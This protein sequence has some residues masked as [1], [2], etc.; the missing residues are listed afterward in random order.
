MQENKIKVFL[1]QFKSAV[2]ST[3]D[4]DNNPFSSYAPIL[5]LDNIFYVHISDIARHSQNI[6]SNKKAS[7]FFIEDESKTQNIFARKRIVFQCNAQMIEKD[8]LKYNNILDTFEETIEEDTIKHLRT[9]KDFNLF[10]FSVY[11]GEAIFGF[12]QAYDI[13]STDIFKLVERKGGGHAK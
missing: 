6:K 5:R 1:E 11:R 9:M 12:G 2:I 7:L 3:I 4:I 13:S 10:E 8:G